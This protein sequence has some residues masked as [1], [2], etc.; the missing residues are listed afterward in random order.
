MRIQLQRQLL[1]QYGFQRGR[2]VSGSL[3]RGLSI[4]FSVVR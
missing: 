1:S 3:R 4:G 2:V